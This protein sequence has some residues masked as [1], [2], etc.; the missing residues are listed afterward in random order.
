MPEMQWGC[1][2]SVNIRAELGPAGAELEIARF[3]H[4]HGKTAQQHLFSVV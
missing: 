3:F 4:G 1:F 2:L